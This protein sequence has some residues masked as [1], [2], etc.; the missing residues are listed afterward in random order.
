MFLPFGYPD[1]VSH[2]YLTFQLWDTC[3]AMCSYLRGVLA[4]QSVLESVGVGKDSVTP[5]AAALQWVMRDGSGMLGGLFFA[6]V[7]GPKFDANVK[8]W[9]LYADVIN[10]FGLTLGTFLLLSI[11][12]CRVQTRRRLKVKCAIADRMYQSAM[13]TCQSCFYSPPKQM[14]VDHRH[15]HVANAALTDW[16]EHASLGTFRVRKA[17]QASLRMIQQELDAFGMEEATDRLDFILGTRNPVAGMAAHGKNLL[18]KY[19]RESNEAVTVSQLTTKPPTRAPLVL[20]EVDPYAVELDAMLSHALDSQV[21]DHLQTELHEF[22]TLQTILSD[23]YK[24]L[25]S[26]GSIMKCVT[27]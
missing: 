13:A 9:R 17:A 7:V 22:Q 26:L 23:A 10:D 15:D 12:E 11:R 20:H 24:R 21:L 1:S 6:Y 25:T 5:L 4:T 27:Q 8:F 18:E 2:E 16:C 14:V 19:M 3:Q